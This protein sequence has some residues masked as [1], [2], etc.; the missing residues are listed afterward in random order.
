MGKPVSTECHR[1]PRARSAKQSING[2]SS[3][4]STGTAK[5][6]GTGRDGQLQPSRNAQGAR[7]QMT[8]HAHPTANRLARSKGTGE[9]VRL[10]LDSC[11]EGQL[12]SRCAA[13]CER[14]AWD[15]ATQDGFCRKNKAG[16]PN[17]GSACREFQRYAGAE[18]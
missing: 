17:V 4:V 12:I 7:T 18:G 15:S 13:S 6:K 10:P 14:S 5:A 2:S 11:A 9:G 16:F 1:V 8:H 3:S